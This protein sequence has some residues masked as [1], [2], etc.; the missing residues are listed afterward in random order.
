M[1]I[2]V[3]GP[4]NT[5]KTTFLKDFLKDFPKYKTT[6]KTYR[7]VIAK[8]RLNINQKTNEKSQKMIMEFLYKEITKNKLPNIL[9]DRCL[10][11]NYVYSYCAYLKGE[12]SKEFIL[13]TQRKMFD[14]LKFLDVIIFIPTSVSVKLINDNV[15]DIDTGFIDL[16]NKIFFEVLFEISHKTNILIFVISG[17]RAERIRQVRGKLS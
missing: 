4:Q 12:I 1:R 10:I 7:D 3:I 9:F 11:D 14:H 8:N 16:V 6:K 5:G 15:R 17:N 13:V 2:A